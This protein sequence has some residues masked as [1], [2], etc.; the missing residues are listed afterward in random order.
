MIINKNLM[1]NFKLVKNFER[2]RSSKILKF[3]PLFKSTFKVYFEMII[4][5]IKNMI[6]ITF[7]K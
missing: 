3:L 2:Y 5:H 4:I 7:E 6:I 1:K